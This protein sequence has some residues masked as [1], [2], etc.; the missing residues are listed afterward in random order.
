MRPADQHPPHVPPSLKPTQEP[1]PV[2]LAKANLTRPAPTIASATFGI[3]KVQ[4]AFPVP[5]SLDSAASTAL[6]PHAPCAL[7][8]RAR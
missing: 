4:L 1:A 6:Q 2:S 5:V 3:L 7:T 8:V